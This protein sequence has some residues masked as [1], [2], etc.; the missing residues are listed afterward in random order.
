MS[1]AHQRRSSSNGKKVE[2]VGLPILSS[3]ESPHPEGGGIAD[4]GAGDLATIVLSLII[5]SIDAERMGKICEKLKEPDPWPERFSRK[6]KER[7]DGV[8]KK[9]KDIKE[10]NRT[11]K[12]DF[13]AGFLPLIQEA[14][15]CIGDHTAASQSTRPVHVQHLGAEGQP[16]CEALVNLMKHSDAVIFAFDQLSGRTP[17]PS[18]LPEINASLKKDRE[19]AVATVEAGKRVAEADVENLLADRFQEVRSPVGIS[20]E[21]KQR[22]RMLLS[23]GVNG[24][25]STKEPL[26]WGNI[27]R[28]AERA[29]EKLCFAGQKHAKDH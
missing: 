17:E 24:D 8:M 18:R 6:I 22:G 28:D 26:G 5:T 10:Q 3:D 15:G 9:L 29:L 23:R 20:A 14:L 21:E 12:R 19:V 13:E 16:Y 4:G 7:H 27:A 25:T 1:H 11:S 2:F